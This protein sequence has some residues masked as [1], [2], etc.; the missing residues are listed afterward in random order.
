VE[1]PPEDELCLLLARAQLSPRA[2]EHALGLLRNP[3]RWNFLSERAEGFGLFPLL[4]TGLEALGLQAVPDAVRANWA[5]I[6]RIHAIR[7]ELI[8]GELV[9]ILRSLADAGIPVMPLKGIA[10]AESLYGDAAL[11]ISDDIDVLVLPRHTV[12][13]FRILVSSGWKSEINS[14]PRLL[15]LNARYGK[16]CLLIRKEPAYT[17]GLELHSALVWGASLESGLLE[18]VW[19]EAQRITFRGVPAFALSAEWEFLY[20]A[21]TA[22]RHGGS[23]LKWYVD[24]DRFCR[25]RSIDWK[26]T[27]EKAMSLGWAA[28]V[29]SSLQVCSSLFETPVGPAFSSTPPQH[30]VGVPRP[31]ALPS[32]ASN[33][34]LF[35]LLDTPTRKLRYLGIRLFIP[36]LADCEFLRLPQS[37]FFLYYPLRPF[38][39]IVKVGGWFLA[40]GIKKLWCLLRGVHLW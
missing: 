32:P 21:I 7:T 25:Q 4:Y 15:E 26:K 6:F 12:E 34:F 38:R 5:S 13:A 3:L 40:A 8:A 28:A 33:V 22:H 10:L 9:R 31:S 16:D 1:M 35:G 27:G 39:V 19:A 18:Q 29:R 37:L 30:R 2:R 14:Q 36:T 11:R 17:V 24:L 20:L 23:S